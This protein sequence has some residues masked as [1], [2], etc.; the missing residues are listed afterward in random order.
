[1]EI[2]INLLYFQKLGCKHLCA[3]F[4]FFLNFRYLNRDVKLTM[5]QYI[6]LL[7]GFEAT[8]LVEV[9][10]QKKRDGRVTMREN[11]MD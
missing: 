9:F 3:L 10:S 2:K 11:S 8:N 1:M 6:S 4:N 5:V 7:A